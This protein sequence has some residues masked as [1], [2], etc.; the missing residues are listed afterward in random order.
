MSLDSEVSGPQ[1]I[2]QFQGGL[3]KIDRLVAGAINLEFFWAIPSFRIA[4]EVT[5]CLLQQQQA[6]QSPGGR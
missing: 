4:L 1:Q 5:C 6:A 3:P 2:Q